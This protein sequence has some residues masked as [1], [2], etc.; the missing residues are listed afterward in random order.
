ME[1]GEIRRSDKKVSA[2]RNMETLKTRNDMFDK[3][4]WAPRIFRSFNRIFSKARS[5]PGTETTSRQNSSTQWPRPLCHNMSF[6]SKIEQLWCFWVICMSWLDGKKW[7]S[8]FSSA[9][10]SIYQE[11][12][13]GADHTDQV[14]LQKVPPPFIMSWLQFPIVLAIAM[15]VNKSQGQTFDRIRLLLDEPI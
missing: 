1:K 13:I 10:S 6:N 11:K 2:P 14:Q 8:G 3:M 9:S 15:T 12:R 5:K 7:K 4:K